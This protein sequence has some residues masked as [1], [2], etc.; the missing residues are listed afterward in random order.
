MPPGHAPNRLDELV[1]S[2][3][4]RL[5]QLLGGLDLYVSA[6]RREGLSLAVLE[7]MALGLPV[8]ATRVAGHVDAVIDGVTGRLVPPD[9]PGALG[10][11]LESLLGEPAAAR[12]ALGEAGR[13]RV[14]QRFGVERM[15][16]ETAALYRAVAR[17][18]EGK[19]ST[20]VV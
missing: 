14:E 18:P 20:S 3:F 4:A 11:A 2:P 9:Q 15:A 5:T 6:S 10:D 12:R 8:V 13:R 17:F 16:A 7:A 1:R 19:S